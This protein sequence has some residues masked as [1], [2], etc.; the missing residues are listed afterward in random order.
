MGQTLHHESMCSMGS[1]V[2]LSNR[3]HHT[4]SNKGTEDNMLCDVC[5]RKAWTKVT[6]GDI[7]RAVRTTA[8]T[9]KLHE[10]VIDLNMIG[11][12]SLRAGGAMELKIMGYKDSTI[13]KCIRCMSG[14]WKIYIHSQISKLSEGVSQ[15]MSTTNPYQNISF[16]GP[17]QR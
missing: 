16:V 15:K 10:R 8:K 13:I 2:S 11:A 17:H 5:I 12:H 4:L 14:T 9:L 3:V 1:M 6:S 7:F